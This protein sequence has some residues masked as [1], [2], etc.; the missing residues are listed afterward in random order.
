[1]EQIEAGLRKR[2]RYLQRWK[3]RLGIER[4]WRRP[5]WTRNLRPQQG[6][7][8]KTLSHTFWR[9]Y[10]YLW[11]HSLSR[12][13]SVRMARRLGIKNE[14]EPPALVVLN[15]EPMSEELGVS[16][17]Q[18]R[19]HVRKWATGPGLIKVGMTGPKSQK[20]KGVYAIGYW[21]PE[22]R[23]QWFTRERCEG[24]LRTVL[25]RSKK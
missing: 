17:D 3:E 19:K 5:Q 16:K 24:W 15:T 21:L 6:E 23:V 4:V 9:V 8:S 14:D 18:I 10:G 25:F 13:E 22:R 7:Y 20:G 12:A 2:L 11:T 1:V